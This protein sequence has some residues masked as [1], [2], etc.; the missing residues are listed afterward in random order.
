MSIDFEGP[1]PLYVQVAGWIR[2]R[3]ESGEYAADRPIPSKVSLRQEL[4]VSQGVVEQALD[5][6][7]GEGRIRTVMGRGMYVT[8]RPGWKPG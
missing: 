5:V 2:D 3:I 1:V 4:G 8:P 6:L 7:R